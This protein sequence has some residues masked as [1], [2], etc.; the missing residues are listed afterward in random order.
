MSNRP[1]NLRARWH[2]FAEL[3]AALMFAAMFMAFMIQ[4]ISRYVFNYPVSWSLEICSV[5][6][7]WV[8]FWTSDIL[9]SERQHIIFDILYQ[10]LPPRGRRVLGLINTLTLGGIFLVGLPATLGYIHFLSRRKTMTLHLP[11]ELVY[12]CF[13]IFMIAVIVSAAIRV[14]RLLGA[15]WQD[16]L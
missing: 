5:A 1:T 2:R 13:G 3:A 11:L 4:I 6:Y 12:S 15:T 14:K 10:K 16:H 9:V 8:V 7:I